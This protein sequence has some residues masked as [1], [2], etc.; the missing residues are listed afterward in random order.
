MQSESIETEANQKVQY[1]QNK[2]YLGC[3]NG[4]IIRR[5]WICYH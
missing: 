4:L 5:I 2:F 1:D 3:V